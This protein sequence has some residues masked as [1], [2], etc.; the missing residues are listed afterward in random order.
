MNIRPLQL[1]YHPECLL[2]HNLGRVRFIIIGGAYPSKPPCVG[3]ASD[4]CAMWGLAPIYPTP[5]P[6]PGRGF[7]ASLR[8][9]FISRGG[10][11]LRKLL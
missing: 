2:A 7:V 9:C 11:I 3:S 5:N 4:S 6:F 8:N 10:V 1:F